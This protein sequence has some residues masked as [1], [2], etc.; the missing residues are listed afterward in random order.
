MAQR[1]AP[2][3][4]LTFF[5]IWFGQVI[6]LTGSGLTG[7]AL[8]VWVYQRTGSVTQFALISLFTSLP[9]IVMSP[10]A[11]ALVDRWDRR[12]AMLLSDTGAGL[13]T[14]AIALLLLAGHLEVWHIYI[15]LAISSTFSAFQ[16]PAYS[17]ATTLLVPKEHLGRASG[18]VQL[19]EAA[20]QIVSPALAG[21]L[22]GIIQ[23]QGVILIDFATFLF[24]VLTL[25]I[26]RVPR[27]EAT[28]EGQA[29][30][31]SLLREAAYGWTYITARPGLLGLLVFFAA[32]NFTSGIVGVL[33]TPLVL[34]FSTP[35]VL[36]SLLSIGGVG[37]LI[38]SLTMSAWGGPKPR[39]YGILGFSILQGIVLFAAGLPP[40]VVIL[41]VAAF[42]YFFS[43]PV[44]NGCS[45]AIWQSKV[46]PDVQ[47]RVF[48]VRRMIAWSSLPLAYLVA[49]PLADRV[50]EPLL[51]VG[52][53]LAASVGQLVGVGPGR[54]IGFLYMVLGLIS[55]L[56]VV[57]AL[58]YPR[59]RR[60][61]A[62]LPDVI[63]EKAP[64][65]S[66]GAAPAT[67]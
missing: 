31:G 13:C 57:V 17:A 20:A 45:Q 16:W 64:V 66:G 36:G 15:A 30:Q 11:G 48:A 54:G 37:F 61:E 58:L 56:A 28:A 9:G 51:A 19:G 32:T 26:I 41:A 23:I 6:S 62:E 59:L 18:M 53:P 3:G 29:G 52:G 24:A 22:V 47:G 8:G 33:F 5:T 50:F 39:V 60:V 46:A 67:G 65:A 25:L 7:F 49:G 34:G 43:L 14:L 63:G 1:T 55:L 40:R 21:A 44:V 12:T 2:R 42:F 27:P 10:I 38:G 35:A 4:M